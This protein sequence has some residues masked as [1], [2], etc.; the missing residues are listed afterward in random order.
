MAAAA[1]A[2]VTRS[3]VDAVMTRP[4]ECAQPSS[5]ARRRPCH[6][7]REYG[8]LYSTVIC[9]RCTAVCTSP[10]RNGDYRAGRFLYTAKSIPISADTLLRVFR[11]LTEPVPYRPTLV[12]VNRRNK[13]ARAHTL[14]CGWAP[15]CCGTKALHRR[16]QSYFRSRNQFFRCLSPAFPLLAHEQNRSRLSI[17]V[18]PIYRY[19]ASAQSGGGK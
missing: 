13:E 5:L 7:T 9:T 3:A 2:S 16:H 8:E 6:V 11:I 15:A 1:I 18:L 12:S 10:A 14:Q 17:R 19:N 4:A